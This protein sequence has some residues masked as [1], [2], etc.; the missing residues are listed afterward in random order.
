MAQPSQP[1]PPQRGAGHG[2]HRPQRRCI[3]S[4]EVRDKAELL[5]F[6]VGPSGEIVPDPG[7]ELPGRGIWCLP[8]RDMLER[9]RRRR[10][11]A[12]AARQAVTVPDDLADRVAAQ[13]RD[14]CL[15]RL[16]LAQRA[17]EVVAGFAKVRVWLQQ[18]RAA[19]LLEARDGA[20]DG[21]DRLR[22]LARA[23]RPE[24]AVIGLFRAEE[25]GAALGRASCVHV[26]LGDGGHAERL[27][28]ECARLAGLLGEDDAEARGA[29]GRGSDEHG[30]DGPETTE[31]AQ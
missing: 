15:A 21:R 27:Q 6:V 7:E 5:R 16:G 1:T 29:S 20:P 31:V 9:A 10:Q 22:R 23:V 3:A 13:L 12:R 11:F 26:A 17:G 19:V 28:R 14:R 30:P 2:R 18:G 4:G 25:L 8:R 24:I